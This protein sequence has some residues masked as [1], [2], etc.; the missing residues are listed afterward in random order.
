MGTDKLSGIKRCRTSAFCVAEP[1]LRAWYN[2]RSLAGSRETARRVGLACVENFG[3][4]HGSQ[5]NLRT[6]FE[7]GQRGWCAS[8]RVL[9]SPPHIS[10]S[11]G[12]ERSGRKWTLMRI[13]RHSNIKQCV[14]YCRSSDQAAHAAMNAFVRGDCKTGYSV[15]KPRDQTAKIRLYSSLTPRRG[16]GVAE[17]GCLLSSYPGKT[18]IGGSNPPLSAK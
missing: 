5:V 11:T 9:Q 12:R 7:S 16:A 14:A 17:Q 4:T 18:G 2:S 13:A 15:E 3:G 6:N 8:V 10:H 1:R